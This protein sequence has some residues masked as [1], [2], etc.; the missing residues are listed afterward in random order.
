MS[1]HVP[2]VDVIG[3]ETPANVT[4]CFPWRG[5][6]EA[7]SRNWSYSDVRGDWSTRHNSTLA[8]SSCARSISILSKIHFSISKNLIFYSQ[9]RSYGLVNG[10]SNILFLIQCENCTRKPLYWLLSE[11]MRL[12]TCQLG[13]L[14]VRSLPQRCFNTTLVPR[15]MHL[16]DYQRIECV[17]RRRR[18][19]CQLELRA[20]YVRVLQRFE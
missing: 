9:H 10:L 13:I 1:S 6:D 2:W 17:R 15:I 20:A 4:K 12:P 18:R 3:K 14:I 11:H 16:T 7:G 8:S 19:E 5:R